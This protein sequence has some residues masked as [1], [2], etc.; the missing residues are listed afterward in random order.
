M[1][2]IL[3]AISNLINNPIL[4]LTFHYAGRNRANG[5]GDALEKYIKDLF[6][7]TL[8][9]ADEYTKVYGVLL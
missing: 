4:D 8:N 1:S 2:N 7:D 9:V 3:Q 5:M 6:A